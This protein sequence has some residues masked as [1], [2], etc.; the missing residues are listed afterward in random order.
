MNL[1]NL[2]PNDLLVMPNF[3]VEQCR[4]W[5]TM[6]IDGCQHEVLSIYFYTQKFTM[7][8]PKAKL[9][10]FNARAL[11]SLDDVAEAFAILKTKKSSTSRNWRNFVIDSHQQMN[12]GEFKKLAQIIKDT[13]PNATKT[14]G[15]HL[16]RIDMH[17]TAIALFTNELMC[18]QNLTYDQAL[19]LLKQ[20]INPSLSTQK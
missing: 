11:A 14:R 5:Q 19:E 12:S 15:A 1:K 2:K 9:A 10:T 3:G 6:T 8:L 13:L 17:N 18:I 7:H 4:G 16:C 20:V